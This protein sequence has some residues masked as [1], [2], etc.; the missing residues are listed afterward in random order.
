MAVIDERTNANL[1]VVLEK[2]A[3]IRFT[4]ASFR[5]P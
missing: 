5:F 3:G 1:D 4:V 2:P